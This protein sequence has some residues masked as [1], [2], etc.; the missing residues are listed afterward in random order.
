M[1]IRILIVVSLSL[2]V[3]GNNVA[4][5]LS[6]E[7]PLD[8]YP[9]ECRTDWDELGCVYNEDCLCYLSPLPTPS[10]DGGL[11]PRPTPKSQGAAVS[12]SDTTATQAYEYACRIAA[13]W[14]G[15]D[16]SICEVY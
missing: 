15:F 9:G 5:V 8:P 12:S 2:L 6:Q 1:K 3:V 10:A 7:S 16:D 4:S 13:R 14:W 11:P